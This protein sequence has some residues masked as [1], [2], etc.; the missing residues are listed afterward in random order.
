ME[1]SVPTAFRFCSR[2]TFSLVRIVAV[3]ISLSVSKIVAVVALLVVVAAVVLVVVDD[4]EDSSVVIDAFIV[5]SG[6]AAT[7]PRCHRSYVARCRH[8]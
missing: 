4:D 3:S 1:H 5:A 7:L 6:V 8:C 2:R